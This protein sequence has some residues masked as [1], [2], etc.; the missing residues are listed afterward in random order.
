MSRLLY[1]KHSH[2][3]IKLAKTTVK[4]TANLVTILIVLLLSSVLE[5][6]YK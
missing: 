6:S 1:F 2:V 5:S 4:N 3:K